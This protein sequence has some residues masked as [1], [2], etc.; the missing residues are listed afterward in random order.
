MEQQRKLRVG[1]VY[2]GKSGEH[3][4]SLS[5]AQAVMNA[6]DYDKYELIPFYIMKSGQWRV[7]STLEGPLSSQEDLQ[8]ESAAGGTVKAMEML[9]TGLESPSAT[10]RV[11]M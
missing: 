1:I 2:G 5:T 9:F 10:S 11:L 3:E 6:F 4:V 8:L 7:G